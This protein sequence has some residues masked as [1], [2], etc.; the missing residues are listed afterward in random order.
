M[1]DLARER[2]ARLRAGAEA[3]LVTDTRRLGRRRRRAQRS[4]S[5]RARRWRLQRSQPGPRSAPVTTLAR[6]AGF[7]ALAERLAT[8]GPAAVEHELCCFVD[9]ARMHGA[10]P[11]LVSILTDVSQPDVARQRAFGRILVEL[12]EHRRNG[13]RSSS[14]VPDA[15]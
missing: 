5:L 9:H 15:A 2:Q 13:A 3:R 14:V 10:T 6:P 7:R 8:E 12:A 4:W 1:M 11:V